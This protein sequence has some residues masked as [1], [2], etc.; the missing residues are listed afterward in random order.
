MHASFSGIP[1][2]LPW[3]VFNELAPDNRQVPGFRRNMEDLMDAMHALSITLI[4]ALTEVNNQYM[5]WCPIPVIFCCG[6]CVLVTRTSHYRAWEFL[7]I[8]WPTP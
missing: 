1:F 3:H 7:L 8:P 5:P 6:T 4:E 2:A